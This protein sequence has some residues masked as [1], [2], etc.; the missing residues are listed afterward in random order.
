M[1][2]GLWGLMLSGCGATE[3]Q[4][5]GG[6]ASE[7]LPV[8][9]MSVTPDHLD[10]GER[11][12]RAPEAPLVF[13]VANTGDAPLEIEGIGLSFGTGFSLPTPVPRGT[14]VA[15]GELLEV[16]V[17]FSPEHGFV[18]DGELYVRSSDPEQPEARVTLSGRGATPLLVFDP[19]LVDLGEL[20][21]SCAGE[22]V[23]TLRNEGGEDLVIDSI[24]MT[25]AEGLD[26]DGLPE[27]PLTLPAG[28]ETDLSLTVQYTPDA[29]GA[30]TGSVVVTSNDPVAEKLVPIVAE[31]G[32]RPP[33]TDVLIAETTEYS[34]I[35][36]A[37]DQSC[38]MVNDRTRL[39]E[40]FAT[41]TETL[42]M[43]LSGWQVGIVTE[44][45]GCFNN[46]IIT[47][48]TPSYSSVMADAVDGRGGVF[49]EALLRLSA[50]AAEESTVG[51][52]N[53][54]FIREATLLHVVVVSDEPEQ[55]G[56]P[57]GYLEQLQVLKG[58]PERVVVS[59]V[60]A[61][62]CGDYSG[63][64][65]AI[66]AT[67]GLHIDLCDESWSDLV[68]ELA[69]RSIGPTNRVQLSAVPMPGTVSVSVDGVPISTWTLDD[70]VVVLLMSLVGLER[71]EVSYIPRA[72]CV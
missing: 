51:R 17:A 49:T 44:D 66:V 69:V 20:D 31:V 23:L 27:L 9:V 70:G 3:F 43:A 52:C 14:E 22:Q 32:M 56:D 45:N 36:F 53:E 13:R 34:D 71:V 65:D 2:R 1:M 59:G 63:Y 41:F 61:L 38:S 28:I 42:S 39:A 12:S 26:L 46:G 24:G 67:G 54:G 10:F 57:E 37:I 47:A 33:I 35:L 48:E 55:S 11:S 5:I 6:G 58:D 21:V 16:S 29:V 19:P 68:E 18:S 60:L 7:V 25:G 50:E 8:A 15:S 62:T 64:D 30:A 40:G 4:V 72:E